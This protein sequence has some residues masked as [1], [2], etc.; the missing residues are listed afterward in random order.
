[1][2]CCYHVSR[3]MLRPHPTA[4]TDNAQAHRDLF[5][6]LPWTSIE[7]RSSFFLTWAASCVKV[8][9]RRK[10][11]MFMQSPE[12]WLLSMWPSFLAQAH[13]SRTAPACTVRSH[14]VCTFPRVRCIPQLGQRICQPLPV[15][16]TRPY[17]SSSSSTIFVAIV[18]V[19]NFQ[20]LKKK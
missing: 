14:S 8:V 6:Q 11:Q 13:E 5:P 1:M 4:V 16:S 18:R 15:V 3:A 20:F 7:T 17:S 10:P 12:V 2:P 9:Q 19:S